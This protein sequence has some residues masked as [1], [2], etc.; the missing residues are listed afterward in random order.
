MPDH[1]P[2]DQPHS[3]F[4]NA[5][6]YSAVQRFSIKKILKMIGVPTILMSALLCGL[7]ACDPDTNTNTPAP[8]LTQSNMDA[9][10][11][12]RSLGIGRESAIFGYLAKK[13]QITQI[14]D[15]PVQ[16]SVILNLQQIENGIGELSLGANCSPVR[17]QFDIGELSKGVISTKEIERELSECSNTFEDRLMSTLADLTY[18]EK[19]PIN[20]TDTLILSAYQDKITLIPAP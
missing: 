9:L 18:I 15:I 8:S 20:T 2:T 19:R 6:K 7:T 11:P 3:S 1:L 10:S 16:S 14:N 5:P 4:D 12:T 17:I 13:W